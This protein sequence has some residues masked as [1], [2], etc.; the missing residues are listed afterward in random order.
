[1]L[2]RLDHIKALAQSTNPTLDAASVIIWSQVYIGYSL[3]AC[4]IPCLKPFM[5]ACN[6]GFVASGLTAKPIGN[7][8]L[9]TLRRHHQRL[10]NRD[11]LSQHDDITTVHSTVPEP[12]KE[13]K[14]GND[15]SSIASYGSKQ[16]MI[17]HEGG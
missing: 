14:S 10:A 8:S 9:S 4:T 1:M 13:A 6:T 12:G 3:I 15:E 11:P 2:V 7:Y 5:N 17:R 16:T